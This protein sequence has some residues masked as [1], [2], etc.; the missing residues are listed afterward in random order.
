MFILI[1]FLGELGD[2]VVEEFH[3]IGILVIIGV[4]FKRVWGGRERIHCVGL[5]LVDFPSAI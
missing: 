5:V 3:A 4:V 2:K 1:S